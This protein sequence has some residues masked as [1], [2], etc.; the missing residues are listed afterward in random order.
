MR[1][2]LKVENDNK[3]NKNQNGFGQFSLIKIYSIVFISEIYEKLVC[4]PSKFR[5]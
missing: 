4:W 5:S 3:E 1:I 2:F